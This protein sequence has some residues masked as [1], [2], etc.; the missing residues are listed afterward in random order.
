MQPRVTILIC[1]H[2]YGHYIKDAINS[3]LGQTVDCSICVIDDCS[4]DDSWQVIHDSLFKSVP[5]NKSEQNGL[6]VKSSNDGRFN[7]IRLPATC[8]PSEARNVG[9]KA[10]ISI[11]DAYLILDADDIAKPNKVEVL[12]NKLLED[13]QL[14]G[15]VYADYDNYNVDTKMQIREFK[16]PF[17]K[18]RLLEECI[19]HSGALINAQA[20]R[21]TADQ[22]GFYDRHLRCC[23]DYDLW[24]RISGTYI[25]IH[26]P[27]NLTFVRVHRNNSTFGVNNIVWQECMQRLRMKLG[28][29]VR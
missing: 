3:A 23:E 5:H 20:L 18:V 4:T 6:E 26:V 8:G 11:T 25:I 15:V 16:E 9:I 24:L 28:G 27:Q 19:V 14:I 13:P 29:Y 2:N 21:E 17:D 12:L 10:T 1:N 22:N 7:A